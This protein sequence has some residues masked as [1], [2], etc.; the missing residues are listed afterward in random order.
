MGLNEVSD[1]AE[2]GVEEAAVGAEGEAVS[3][4][5]DP[6]ADEAGAVVYVVGLFDVGFDVGGEEVEGVGGV[7]DV[8]VAEDFEHAGEDEVGFVVELLELGGAEDEFVGDALV[9]GGLGFDV[10]GDV[11]AP[12]VA[13]GLV[14]EEVGGG[15]EGGAADESANVAVQAGFDAVSVDGFGELGDVGV[16]GLGEVAFGGPGFEF[17]GGD[18]AGVDAVG[19]VV[20]GVGGVIGPVHD[21]AFD[22]AEGVAV[23]AGG[24]FDGEGFAAE[25]EVEDGFLVV[26]EVVVFGLGGFGA[27]GFVFEYGVEEGAGGG[28]ALFAFGEEG[29]GEE[30]EGLGIAFEAAVGAHEAVEGAFAGVAEG[31]MAEVMG[32]AGALD[33]V[34]VDEAVVGEVGTVLLEP[35]ADGA[36]DLGDFDGVGEAVAVEVVFAGE[37]DLG[38]ALEAAEGGGVDDA[39]AVDLE[40]GAVFAFGGG[41]GGEGG[42]VEG[43]VEAVGRRPAG[44]EPTAGGGGSKRSVWR[45]EGA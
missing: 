40:G 25:G 26:V 27:E 24:E 12:L 17:G 28:D 18:E 13:L 39:V 36:A 37:E 19:E 30:A 11:E 20:E 44:V 33:E 16:F 10:G 15:L 2:V 1:G 34:G 4:G 9:E 7:L 35:A 41:P 22:G 29:L 6:V 5:G 45:A 38:F 3:H 42:E 21:L 31:G 32:K 23:V 43:V 14:A 8:A